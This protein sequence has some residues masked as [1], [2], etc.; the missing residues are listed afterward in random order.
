MANVRLKL[1]PHHTKDIAWSKCTRDFKG[2]EYEKIRTRGGNRRV[3]IPPDID[4]RTDISRQRKIQLTW[5]RQ[6]LCVTCGREKDPNNSTYCTDHAIYHRERQRKRN[7]AKIRYIAAGS[8]V[9]EFARIEKQQ[10]N[11]RKR[12]K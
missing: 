1:C 3:V 11:K 2:C 7:A 5:T 12:R 8:Y 4:A 10:G 9:S 6:G